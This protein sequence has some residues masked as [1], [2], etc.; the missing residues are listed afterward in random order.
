MSISLPL[1]CPQQ[2]G[3]AGRARR[4]LRRLGVVGQRGGAG[5][6]GGCCSLIESSL[7]ARLS[8]APT[9]SCGAGSGAAPQRLP[10]C[11]CRPAAPCCPTGARPVHR[12]LPVGRRHGGTTHGWAAGRQASPRMQRCGLAGFWLQAGSRAAHLP[13]K[14]HAASFPPCLP[15]RP[16]RRPPRA[17]GP[18]RPHGT[19][20][21]E[22]AGG[23]WQRIPRW[24][25]WGSRE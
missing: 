16:S 25:G 7:A 24:A 10:F 8:A 5:T 14:T 11:T 3:G 2:D 4:E 19:G 20:A 17:A 6:G 23:L 22:G 12:T 21:P 15:A 13:C 18:L 1:P 9:E